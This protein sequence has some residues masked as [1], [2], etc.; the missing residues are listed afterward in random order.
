MRLGNK[1]GQ[2]LVFFP[3]IVVFLFGLTLLVIDISAMVEQKIRMQTAADSAA[4]T[5]ALWMAYYIDQI[6]S[7]NAPLAPLYTAL[8]SQ[9]VCR[10]PPMRWTRPCRGWVAANRAARGLIA[11]QNTLNTTG[12]YLSKKRA[13]DVAKDNGA[14]NVNV[15]GNTDFYLTRTFALTPGYDVAINISCM[16]VVGFGRPAGFMLRKDISW[17][18]GS[19]GSCHIRERMDV[20]VSKSGAPAYGSAILGQRVRFPTIEAVSSAR[21]YWMGCIVTGKHNPREDNLNGGWPAANENYACMFQ[22]RWDAKLVT[23]GKN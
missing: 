1:G 7:G 10:W 15:G 3:F 11:L 16:D 22:G 12:P 13:Q 18:L 17:S 4:R 9:C 2:I 6:G 19:F 8:T 14:T 20:R 23:Y 21:P 5:G